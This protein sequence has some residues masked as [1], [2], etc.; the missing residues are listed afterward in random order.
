MHSRKTHPSQPYP[1]LQIS[2]GLLGPTLCV[3]LF[4]P[5]SKFVLPGG[6]FEKLVFVRADL[7][8]VMGA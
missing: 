7:D 6:Y 8:C 1:G 2:S 5:A 4:T 3:A